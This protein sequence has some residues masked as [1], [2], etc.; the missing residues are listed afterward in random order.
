[1]HAINAPV[2]ATESLQILAKYLTSKFSDEGHKARA[3][4]RYLVT[5][6]ITTHKARAI[7]RY[8]VTSL[9][10]R[11]KLSTG[12]DCNILKHLQKGH[13]VDDSSQCKSKIRYTHIIHYLYKLS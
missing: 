6:L 4:Y 7:Y 11:L 3:I 9:I 8:L 10:T 1:M 2:E 5:S 12:I 13:D